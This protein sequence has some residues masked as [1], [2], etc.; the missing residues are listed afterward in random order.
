MQIFTIH[1]TKA[2]SHLQPFYCE[3][4]EV[5]LRL[6]SDA[7]QDP[8][9]NFNKHAGD[10]HLYQIGEF[11][12]EKGEIDAWQKIHITCLDA[13]ALTPSHLDAPVAVQGGE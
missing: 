7:C 8:T 4:Q 2:N 11:N 1:D 10:Y 9:H 3:T 13:L 5:A 6:L 12:Q